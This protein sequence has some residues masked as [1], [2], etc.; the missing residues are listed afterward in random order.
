MIREPVNTRPQHSSAAARAFVY[1][2]ALAIGKQ[3]TEAIV[4]RA[5]VAQIFEIALDRIA[6]PQDR[7]D[8][9]AAAGRAWPPLF[10]V[11][12]VGERRESAGACQ[13]QPRA[14]RQQILARQDG[15]L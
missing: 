14:A 2:G 4:S 13:A 11:A 15:R 12:I 9:R 6:G 1:G 3:Q 10:W 8:Q 7:G 5:H